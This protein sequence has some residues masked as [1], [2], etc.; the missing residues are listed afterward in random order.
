M[1]AGVERVSR[2]V[3][4]DTGLF[5][6]HQRMSDQWRAFR[7][8]VERTEDIPIG[9]LVQGATATDLAD[10][11]VRGYE[12]PF[13]TPA[14]KAGARAF[15]LLIPLTPDAPG[16]AE[17]RSTLEALK[18]FEGE[19]LLLWADGDPVLPP[20]TGERFAEVLGLP[21]PELIP[22]ASHFL[23]EDQGELIGRRIAEW[24]TS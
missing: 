21:E 11:V 10:E 16:A 14:S 22:G 8:F 5:T 1:E 2:I 18:A 19:I 12:A 15:P 3:A 17:G 6:G 4:M 23:Q 9:M 20:S 7:D 24:L 13:P